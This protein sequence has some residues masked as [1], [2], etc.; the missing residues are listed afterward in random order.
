MHVESI[1]YEVD[2]ISMVGHLAFDDTWT[3]RRPAVLLAHEGPGLDGHVRGRAERLASVGYCAFA[4]DYQGGEPT[5]DLG[6]TME[7]LAVLI[8]MSLVGR[9][10]ARAVGRDHQRHVPPH[11]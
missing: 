3:D 4:L 5:Y 2:G 9:D 8:S 6:K 7:R 1:T 11:G 10:S